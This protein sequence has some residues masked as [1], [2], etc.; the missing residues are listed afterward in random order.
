MS[1]TLSWPNG[2]AMVSDDV[3]AE[4]PEVLANVQ[5][6]GCRVA[7]L[8]WIDA[9]HDSDHPERHHLSEVVGYVL[10][11]TMRDYRPLPGRG[12][13]LAVISNP[14]R[15]DQGLALL[16]VARGVPGRMANLDTVFRCGCRSAR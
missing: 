8:R 3:F 6:W 15:Y 16:A 11:Q 7:D 5:L 4:R 14:D 2:V 9:P 13:D 12:V 1:V 10:R